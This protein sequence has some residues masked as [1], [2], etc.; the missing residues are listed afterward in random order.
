MYS[1]KNE[2][3]WTSTQIE[4]WFYNSSPNFPL[5]KFSF[6]T[7]DLNLSISFTMLIYGF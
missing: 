7:I 6:Q 3:E 5:P 2:N 4:K 1:F